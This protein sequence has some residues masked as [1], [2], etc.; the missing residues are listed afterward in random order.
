[1]V[2]LQV[3]LEIMALAINLAANRRNAQE[4]QPKTTQKIK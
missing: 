2:T 3:D 4:R 1:M